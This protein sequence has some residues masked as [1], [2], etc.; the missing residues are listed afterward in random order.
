MATSSERAHSTVGALRARIAATAVPQEPAPRTAALGSLRFIVAPSHPMA[1]H[2]T[3]GSLVIQYDLKSI[4]VIRF[5]HHVTC[6]GA[7]SPNPLVN[8]ESRHGLSR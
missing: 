4:L 7:V 2:I 6:N 8:K 5:T 1:G 3:I